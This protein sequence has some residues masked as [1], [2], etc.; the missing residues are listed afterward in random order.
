MKRNQLILHLY[1]QFAAGTGLGLS[2]VRQIIETNGG[3]IEVNSEP[4]I[5]TKIT[6]KLALN[7]PEISPE[8]ALRQNPSQRSHFLSYI[9]RL[10]GR[11]VSILRKQLDY[12]ADVSVVSQIAEG[13]DR[14]TNVLANTLEKHLRMTVVR[15]TEW[16]GHGSDIVIVPELSFDYLRSIRRSRI[17]GEK[18]PVTIFIAM[19]ALEA[20]TLR[21]DWRV[22]SKES[23]VEIMTQP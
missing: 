14:F 5:G 11:S 22:K 12:P 13:L 3:K 16:T 19:D 15:T 1:I 9:S 2:I 10:Q 8:A 6:V 17:N 7:K 23:V 18:A 21:S 20:A 4:S